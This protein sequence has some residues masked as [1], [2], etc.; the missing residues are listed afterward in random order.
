MESRCLNSENDSVKECQLKTS[1]SNSFNFEDQDDLDLNEGNCGGGGCGGGGHSVVNSGTCGEKEQCCSTNI[2]QESSCKG[3]IT[4]RKM[5]GKVFGK[6]NG[7]ATIIMPYDYLESK[8]KST[9]K[10]EDNQDDIQTSQLGGQ[11]Q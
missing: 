3:S 1:R 10:Y 4:N 5:F 2:G 6:G 8:N 11:N 9:I 7:K